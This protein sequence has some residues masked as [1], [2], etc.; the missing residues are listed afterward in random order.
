VA[1]RTFS[2]RQAFEKL[3]MLNTNGTGR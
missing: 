1:G 2:A 3:V